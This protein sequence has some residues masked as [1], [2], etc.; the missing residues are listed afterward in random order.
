M[1][2]K[3]V[4]VGAG[5]FA[6]EVAWLIQEVNRTHEIYDFLGFVVSD[7]SNLR[8]TDSRSQVLG[9]YEWLENNARGID[10]FAIGIGTPGARLR[11]SS[12]LSARFS[13]IEWPAIVHPS[14]QFDRESTSLGSGALI[15]A[16]VVGTVNLAFAPFSMVNLCCTIGHEARIG[17]GCVINPTV[18]LSGGVTLKRGVL[19]GTGAQI[20]QYIEVGEGATVGAGAVVTKNVLPGETVVGIPAKPLAKR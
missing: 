11:V 18:N 2:K 19:V 1:K 13:H 4:I 8:D 16:G 10:A 20:L 5:G 17:E 15:C 6:R 9:D 14:A 3:I 7:L 12:E